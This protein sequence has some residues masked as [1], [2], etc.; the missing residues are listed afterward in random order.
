MATRTAGRRGV[1]DDADVASIL[2][3]DDDQ[4]FR[5]IARRLLES[6]GFD[7]VGPPQFSPDG[8]RVAFSAVKGRELWWKV[9]EVK[10]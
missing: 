10:P 4:R 1:C 3:V 8:R 9:M 5:G 6:E 2:I 7:V